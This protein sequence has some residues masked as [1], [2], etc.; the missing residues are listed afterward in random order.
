M[1]PDRGD[2][3]GG[4][5]SVA[6]PKLDAGGGRYAHLRKAAPADRPLKVTLTWLERL[7]SEV[8]PNALMQRFAR[9]AN[10][11]AASWSDPKAFATYMDSLLDDK[12]G[13]RR[14]FPPEVQAELIVL[15]E[16][17]ENRTDNDNDF[18][19]HHIGKRG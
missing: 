16:Y 1:H 7:P 14:G 18:V 2:G 3:A 13:D 12:R 17:Y 4:S 9:V 15:K 5:C 6:A 19:W 8:Q 10:L 11:I